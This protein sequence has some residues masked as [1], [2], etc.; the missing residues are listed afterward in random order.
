M[1]RLYKTLKITAFS[2]LF[3]GI[4]G[5]DYFPE[6]SIERVIPTKISSPITKSKPE[7]QHTD[8]PLDSNELKV[9]SIPH[10]LPIDSTKNYVYLTFDDGPF[11]G[12]EKINKIIK[13]E[14]VKATVFIV[15]MNAYTQTLQKY[16]KDY[17]EN[18]LIEVSN[19]TYSHANRN[20]FKSYYDQPEFVLRD[21]KRNDSIYRFKNRF[22]R[23][24]GRNVWR[25]GK[26]FKNDHDLGSRLSSDF[27]AKNQYYILGWDYEW[28][29]THKNHPLKN[30]QDIYNGIIKRLEN[31]ETFKE[32]HLVILMHDDMFDNH[33]DAEQLRRLIRLIKNN[34]NIILETASNYPISLS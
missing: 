26:D 11:K 21:V 15:G 28:N 30:P 7:G 22:V 9:D 4:I 19:H 10:Q 33:E 17:E 31:K 1:K 25:L 34:K 23:L 5:C 3:Q 29:K 13:E 32:K 27:L 20:R 12:S 6:N 14:Q 16:L 8:I 24:P 18:D 2:F